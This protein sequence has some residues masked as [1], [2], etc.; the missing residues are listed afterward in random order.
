MSQKIFIGGLKGDIKEE[1]L[2]VYFSHFGQVK[3]IEIPRSKKSRKKGRGYCI[4]EME[5]ESAR[6][7]ILTRSEESELVFQGRKLHIKPYY[8]GE[9]L[10]QFHE[11]FNSRRVYV[12]GL[13]KQ[14][15]D[16]QFLATFSQ[17]G[18]IES[19]YVLRKFKTGESRGEGFVLF[20]QTESAEA[21]ILGSE[22]LRSLG[23]EIKARL[24]N[25]HRVQNEKKK[26][27][28]L[29]REQAGERGNSPQINV[30]SSSRMGMPWNLELLTLKPYKYRYH[31]LMSPDYFNH[32][33]R[34]NLK[35][36]FLSNQRKTYLIQRKFQRLEDG[37]ILAQFR[38]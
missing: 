25:K 10:K 18:T 26:K 38:M 21:A 17:F 14:I 24:Y 13:D 5:L 30:R 3:S 35:L 4:L 20:R 6:K 1:E 11:S 9:A 22:G 15:S 29:E 28:L 7:E 33:Q 23:Q 19:G 16:Q 27:M 37:W 2:M 34:T 32:N 12:S 36:N 8:T 31:L